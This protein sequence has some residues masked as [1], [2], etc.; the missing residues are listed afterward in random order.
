MHNMAEICL[1]VTSFATSKLFTAGICH[2]ACQDSGMLKR[3]YLVPCAAEGAG[4]RA[5]FCLFGAA[6]ASSELMQSPKS[7]ADQIEERFIEFASMIIQFS[8]ELPK[9]PAGRH[10]AMQ[11]LRS[12]TSGAPNDAE[13]RGP[14][15]SADS[16][17]KPKVVSAGAE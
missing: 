7:Q 9:T 13:A 16:T 14:E 15:S 5:G 4:F 17:H 8:T 6:V 2:C 12:G 11:I 10:M 3:G 1:K